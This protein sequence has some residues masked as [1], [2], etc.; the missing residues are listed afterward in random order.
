MQWSFFCFIL[1]TALSPNKNK[2]AVVNIDIE[3]TADIPRLLFWGAVPI[4][5]T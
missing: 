1:N 2:P 4:E 5:K 3:Y